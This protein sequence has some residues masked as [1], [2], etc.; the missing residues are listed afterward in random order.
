MNNRVYKEFGYSASS[1]I[2][3]MKQ[4]DAGSY[5]LFITN[6]NKCRFDNIVTNKS[7]SFKIITEPGEYSIHVTLFDTFT[8]PEFVH[9]PQ[10]K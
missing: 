7:G 8:I 3:T 4:T 6:N 1:G 5:H 9:S 2:F 10:T